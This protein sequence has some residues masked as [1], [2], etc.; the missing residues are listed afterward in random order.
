M[1]PTL[2]YLVPEEGESFFAKAFD[3]PYFNSPLHFHPE[4]ELV[5]ITNSKGKR[6]IG[7]KISDFQEGDL[8]FM[9]ADL[10]HLFKNHPAYYEHSPGLR[11]RSIVIQFQKNAIGKD[12]WALPQ[13]KKFHRLFKLSQKG[14]DITGETKQRLI[15]KMEKIVQLK[16]FDRLLCL[17]EILNELADTTEYNLVSDIDI[18]GHNALDSHRLNSVFQYILENY[19]R[20][21]RLEELSG[22]ICMT[23]TS[24]CRFFQERTKQTFSGI[25]TDIRLAQASKLLIESTASVAD[26]CYDCGYNNLSNFNRHFKAKFS[27]SPHSYRK[28]YSR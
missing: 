13:A 7:N 3:L 12:L 26:I 24:F 25:L 6:Y 17:L 16:G 15:P 23:R 22:L 18:I 4:F 27:I 11:A 21:I 20:E 28:E 1:N 9:G 19:Q 2:E 8:T 10:P 14:I 5:L